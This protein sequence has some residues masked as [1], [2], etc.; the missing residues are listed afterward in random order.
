[1]EP[2]TVEGEEKREREKKVWYC[3]GSFEIVGLS[4]SGAGPRVG[5]KEL[6]K[7]KKRVDRGSRKAEE[8]K[9]RGE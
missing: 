2:R 8:G 4:M 9:E 1:M 5:V 7:G 3:L 6:S